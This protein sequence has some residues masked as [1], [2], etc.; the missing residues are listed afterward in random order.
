G[1]PLIRGKGNRNSPVPLGQHAPVEFPKV[2]QR[3]QPVGDP[4][5]Q[6]PE[7]VFGNFPQQRGVLGT[8]RLQAHIRALQREHR[9]RRASCQICSLCVYYLCIPARISS[10]EA[11]SPQGVAEF[12]P[13]WNPGMNSR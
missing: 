3:L 8:K 6:I 11:V 2:L 7:M 1:G 4:L 9:N 5:E 12:L 10:S 13:L